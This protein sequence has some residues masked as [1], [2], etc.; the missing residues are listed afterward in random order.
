MCVSCFGLVVST[1]Q[2]SGKTPLAVPICG[3]IISTKPRLKSV[4]IF[5]VLFILLYVSPSAT[6]F[7]LHMPVARY[8]LFVLT[9]ESAIKIPPK[10]PV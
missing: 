9:A 2:L 1:C 4:C 7:I 3:E 10:P 8:N 5:F 6:Q